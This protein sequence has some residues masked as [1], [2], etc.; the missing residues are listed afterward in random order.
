VFEPELSRRRFLQLGTATLTGLSAGAWPALGENAATSAGDDA[1]YQT[2]KEPPV[3]AQPFVRWWWNGNRLSKDEIRRELDVLKEAGIGGVEIN[4]IQFPE[5][6]DPIGIESLQWLSEPWLE[7]FQTA[8]QGAK[9]RGMVID[10]IV[11]SGWPFGGRFL[12]REDQ[13]QILTKTTLT[14]TGPTRVTLTRQNLLDQVELDL[15]AKHDDVAKELWDLRL[16]PAQLE[17]FDPGQQ[18]IGQMV[19]GTLTVDVPAGDHVLHIL[20]R[21]TGFA[22]VING[23]PGADGPVL[24]HYNA[25][26]VRRYLDRM[27]DALENKVGSLGRAFRAMFCDSLELEGANWCDDMA[28]QFRRRRGYELEPYLPFVLFQTGHMGNIQKDAPDTSLAEPLRERVARVRYD[29]CRTRLELFNERF[30]Q[31]FQQWC[32]DHGVAGR[33][34]AYGRGYHPIESSTHLDI[35]ECETWIN[36]LM[37]Q[38]QHRAW[39]VVNKCVAS[40]ARLAGEKVISCE[41]MTNVGRVFN[42]SLEDLKLAGDQSNLS[43]VTHSVLHGFNYSPPDA[44]FPGWVRYGTFF[45]ERNPW[46]PYF[47]HWSQYKARLSALFQQC[48]ARADVALLHP[49]PDIWQQAGLQRQ[50]YPQ[51]TQPSYQFQLWEAIHQNGQGCDDISEGLLQEGDAHQGAWH[52]GDRRYTTIILMEVTTLQPASAKALAAFAEAGGRII[53]IGDAPSRSPGY[54]DYQ[55]NDKTV[56]QTI[57]RILDEYGDRCHVVEPPGDDLTGWYQR[58]QETAGM[59]P[60]VQLDQPQAN[61][62]QTAFHDGDREIFFFV[63]SNRQQSIEVTAHFQTGRK[64]PWRW[65][66]ESG[67]RSVYPSQRKRNELRLSLAPTESLVLVFEPELQGSVRHRREPGKDMIESIDGP[68]EVTLNHVQRQPQQVELEQ[69]V[70]FQDDPRLVDFAGEAIYRTRLTLD[71]ATREKTAFLDLGRVAGISHVVVNGQDCGIT[72][73]GLHRYFVPHVMRAGENEIEVRITTTLINYCKSLKNNSTAQ[74]WTRRQSYE[75]AGLLGP[76]RLLPQAD[77]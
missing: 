14:F 3:R 40:G 18:L 55:A 76:V 33:V 72:W 24:N 53:F 2:F 21:Q 56:Q 41:E 65:D 50:P 13:T 8:V 45:S 17:T 29:F 6:A 54:L 39:S 37:H 61:L 66:P 10:S 12:S 28:Q 60:Y 44:P 74:R 22:A 47:K 19:D 59:Q 52:Y 23:A 20:V 51:V 36:P 1:L 64:Q 67:Q 73:Y 43:G 11:G 32:A 70:D 49:L 15:H 25:A 26:A 35:P 42:T 27:S 48:T 16:T 77:L 58:L 7:M 62:T 30:V 31:V 75:T 57:A 38:P 9:A 5:T 34:Q 68:W 63:N 71:Q 4:P 46:W 69:L